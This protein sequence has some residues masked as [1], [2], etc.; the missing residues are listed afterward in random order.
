MANC[1]VFRQ[2]K[3]AADDNCYFKAVHDLM[4]N[5]DIASHQDGVLAKAVPRRSFLSVFR[6][7]WSSR[8]MSKRKISG[9][10]VESQ[11]CLLVSFLPCSIDQRT[12]VL[13]DR[14]SI[15][16]SRAKWRFRAIHINFKRH[17]KIYYYCTIEDAYQFPGELYAYI[18]AKAKCFK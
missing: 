12:I 10:K 3:K 9:R 4:K 2:K 11:F 5:S 8:E 7:K 6:A 1:A 14:A 17:L 16:R 15:S 13:R 18:S